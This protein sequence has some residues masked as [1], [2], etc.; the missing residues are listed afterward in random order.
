MTTNELIERLK[1]ALKEGVLIT[2][3]IASGVEV[4]ICKMCNVKQK[5]DPHANKF[6]HHPDCPVKRKIVSAQ[7]VTQ[8]CLLVIEVAESWVSE[9][10][11]AEPGYLAKSCFYCG[12]QTRHL[13][14]CPAALAEQLLELMKTKPDTTW[15]EIL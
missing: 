13:T 6:V 12:M 2:N 9:T 11:I 8:L 15:N 7:D 1:Q 5:G 10:D 4:T 14:K 3:H